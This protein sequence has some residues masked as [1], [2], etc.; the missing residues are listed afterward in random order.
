MC[1]AGEQS[2]F[3]A[4]KLLRQWREWTSSD[5]DL[6]HDFRGI[7]DSDDIVVHRDQEHIIEKSEEQIFGDNNGI[8][9]DQNLD[10]S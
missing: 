7:D 8:S 3:A 10:K 5:H 6:Y 4:A 1:F 2:D 9:Q